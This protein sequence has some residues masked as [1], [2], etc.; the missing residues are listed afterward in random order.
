MTVITGSTKNPL[1]IPGSLR[2]TSPKPIG[3]ADG[4][5]LNDHEREKQKRTGELRKAFH[6]SARPCSSMH[7]DGDRA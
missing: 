1:N 6:V 7:P 5:E 3:A 2:I 4:N